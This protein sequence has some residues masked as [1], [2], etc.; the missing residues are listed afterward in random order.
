MP[1]NI[2]LLYSDR[3]IAGNTSDYLRLKGHSVRTH[4]H[5][6]D[7]IT[8]ADQNPPDLIIL[9]LALA[10]RSGIEFLYELRSYPEWQAI[11]VI[12]TGGP[13]L[14]DIQ[15]YLPA[16]DQ[17]NVSKYLTEGL[18]SLPRLEREAAQLLRLAAVQ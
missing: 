4:F 10:D 5:P 6:Q 8:S 13:R 2:L 14:A 9:G 3:Q 7:A 1:G 12:V 17:L 11:P 18:T 15:L 16:F